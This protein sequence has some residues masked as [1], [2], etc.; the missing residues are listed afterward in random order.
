VTGVL[1]DVTDRALTVSLL[2][3]FQLPG[4]V[5]NA[6]ANPA[7]GPAARADLGELQRTLE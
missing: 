5:L 1:G 2:Q 6:G 3:E 4:L 7:D